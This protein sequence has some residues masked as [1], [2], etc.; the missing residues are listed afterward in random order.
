MLPWHQR[1]LSL[2]FY[3]MDWR[4]YKKCVQHLFLPSESMNN[5]LP[6]IWPK[7]HYSALPAGVDET[8]SIN[9]EKTIPSDDVIQCLYV[10]GIKPPVYDLRDTL[11]EISKNPTVR[12]TLCCRDSEWQDMQSYYRPVI[13]DN[14][15]ICH[16]YGS[17]LIQLYRRAH[18]FLLV[19]APF[20]YLD[21]AMPVKLMESIS[22]GVPIVS[23]SATAYAN[24]IRKNNIGWIVN[25]P[26]ELPNVVCMLRADPYGYREKI[27]N[28]SLIKETNK[29]T[30]RAE[31]IS[32]T[33]TRYVL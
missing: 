10:G 8:I 7:P 31:K 20:E 32:D 33:L 15:S 17:D 4:V 23:N 3:K 5:V 1:I 11:M 9:V 30:D 27:R 12:L 18:I 6:D 25:K 22:H 28:I 13:Y 24:F 29:W 16:K 2:P 26:A 19:L 21:F 14:I